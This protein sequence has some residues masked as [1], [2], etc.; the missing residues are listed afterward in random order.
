VLTGAE[1]KLRMAMLGIAGACGVEG[2]RQLLSGLPRRCA[3]GG[4]QG[5]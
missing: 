2:F 3:H 5:R 1:K 4:E